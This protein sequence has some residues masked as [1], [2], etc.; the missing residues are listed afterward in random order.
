MFW[1]RAD[2]DAESCNREVDFLKLSSDFNLQISNTFGG[3]EKPC[4]TRSNSTKLHDFYI[5]GQDFSP[6]ERPRLAYD[7]QGPIETGSLVNDTSLF[8]ID[9]VACS[10]KDRKTGASLNFSAK[11]F[12]DKKVWRSDHFPVIVS[13][14]PIAK[15]RKHVRKSNAGWKFNDYKA[16]R[17]ITILWVTS[18]ND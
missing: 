13:R 16:T 11:S 17:A 9:Y 5:V 10:S 2:N 1:A 4:F 7:I 12:N 3:K 18:C 14:V 8:Q 6:S 15:V